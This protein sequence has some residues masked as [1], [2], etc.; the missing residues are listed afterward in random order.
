MA[1]PLLKIITQYCDIYVDD[2]RL[3]ETKS[4]NFPLWALKM[5][6]YLLA[7]LPLL[8]L[9]PELLEY[10]VGEDDT[11]L[12]SPQF[13]SFQDELAAATSGEYVIASAHTGYE[14]CSARIVGVDV[15][16]DVIYT[17]LTCAYQAESGTVVVDLPTEYPAGTV[18]EIDLYKDGQFSENLSAEL[19][20]ILGKAF[21]VV[22]E[23]RFINDWLSNVPKIDDKSFSEQNRANKENA[24][25]ER[26][27]ELKSVLDHA[28][29]RLDEN[30]AYRKTVLG[31]QTGY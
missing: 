11:K 8:T 6:S 28:L 17:P 23:T 22:W 4:T 7:A 14:Y 29:R 20:G 16:G 5:S 18:I 9:P 24:D 25:T 15:Y 26:F 3:K 21:Q 19:C 27:A 12:T 1:T 13:A 10:L 2:D 30:N 31:R